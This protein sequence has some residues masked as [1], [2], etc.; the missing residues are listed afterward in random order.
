MIGGFFKHFYFFSKLTTTLLLFVTTIFLGY[1][2]LK[3]YQTNYGKTHV[4]AFDDKINSLLVII[5]NYSK[6]LNLINKQISNHQIELNILNQ[7]IEENLNSVYLQDQFNILLEENTKLHDRI[8]DINKK[9]IDYNENTNIDDEKSNLLYIINLIKLKYENGS[10]IKAELSL[11]QN[12]INDVSKNAYLEKLFVL[13]DKKFIGIINLQREFDKLMK[14]YLKA[15]YINANNNF[16]LSNL[17]KFFSIEPNI[18]SNF[19]N[20]ILNHFSIIKN[21]L[22]QKDVKS[23]LFYLSKIEN[24]NIFFNQWILEAEEYINFNSNLKYIYNS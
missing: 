15:Y 18:N 11:L 12:H 9:L 5:D 10:D 22:N 13:S 6:D 19:K 14:D 3:A 20:D 2:F 16:F 21:K 24:N 8:E 1:I 7:R 4:T 23:A 17:S